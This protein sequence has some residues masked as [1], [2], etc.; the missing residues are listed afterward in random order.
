MKETATGKRA[1][2]SKCRRRIMTN[3]VRLIDGI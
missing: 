1:F 3:D 2:V